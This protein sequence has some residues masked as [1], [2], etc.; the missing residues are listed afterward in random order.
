MKGPK[1]SEPD[2]GGVGCRCKGRRRWR[3]PREHSKVGRLLNGGQVVEGFG[4]R[5][6]LVGGRSGR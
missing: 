6:G 4:T 3:S 5:W 2:E 1:E